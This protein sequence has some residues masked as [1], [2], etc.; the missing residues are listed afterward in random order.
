[1]WVILVT[2]N[3]RFNVYFDY[4]LSNVVVNISFTIVE[5][6]IINNNI[7]MLVYVSQVLVNDY[8]IIIL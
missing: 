2:M 6:M 3:F 7:N 1:M 5:I 8:F 4:Y